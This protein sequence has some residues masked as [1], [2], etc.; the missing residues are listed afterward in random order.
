MSKWRIKGEMVGACSCDWGCP[1]NFDARPTQGWCQGGYTWHIR[2]GTFN[3]VDLSG[4]SFSSYGKFP[5]PIHEG[6]G[7]M[8]SII[9][10]RA[11]PAQREALRALLRGEAGGP[12]EI[13]AAVS[14]EMHDPV[15]APYE[16]RFDKINSYVKAG[17]YLEVGVAPVKNPV[18]GDLEET[19]LLKP[20]GFTSTRSE[21]GMSTVARVKLPAFQY[22]HSGKYAEYAEFEYSGEI[23]V[24]GTAEAAK[25]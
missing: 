16:A 10:E 23:A 12:F 1:C 14:A 15:V 5:G 17:D 4:L 8:Q 21:L 18:T 20:T 7:I 3:G 11:S 25:A 9:D 22:D 2:E 13:F 6:N 24:A 19:T